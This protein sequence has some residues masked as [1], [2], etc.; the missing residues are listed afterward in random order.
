M[1]CGP[2]FF[3]SFSLFF[4]FFVQVELPETAPVFKEGILNRKNEMDGAH[5][6]VPRGK[7]YWRP[8]YAYLK[9]FLLYFVPVGCFLY[10]ISIHCIYALLLSQENGKLNLE[11]TSNALVVTHCLAMRAGDYHKR[12][13]VMRITTSDWH[14]FLLQARLVTIVM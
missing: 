12:S 6:K 7:R 1:D 11:D 9:G 5:K 4:F 3:I 2:F 14:A 13:S 10:S 8:Y